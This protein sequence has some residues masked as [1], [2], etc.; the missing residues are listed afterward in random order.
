MGFNRGH[1][2]LVRGKH[3]HWGITATI[4]GGSKYPLVSDEIHRAV[5]ARLASL[6]RS[7]THAAYASLGSSFELHVLDVVAM[8]FD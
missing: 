5:Q 8:V 1:E 7:Q 6:Q 2:C 4:V 3:L